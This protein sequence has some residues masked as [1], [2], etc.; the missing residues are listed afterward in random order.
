MDGD[1]VEHSIHLRYGAVLLELLFR[2]ERTEFVVSFRRTWR[3]SYVEHFAQH[4]LPGELRGAGMDI[5]LADP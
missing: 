3:P 4:R 2:A 5:E 1:F